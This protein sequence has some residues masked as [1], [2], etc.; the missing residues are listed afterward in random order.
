MTTICLEYEGSVKTPWYPLMFVVNTTS[1]TVGSRFPWS[2]PRKRVPSSR[3]RN[4]GVRFASVKV[5]RSGFLGP[6]RRRGRFLTRRL[7]RLLRIRRRRLERERISGVHLHGRLLSER[8]I[9]H[10]LGQRRATRG[11]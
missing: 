5:T 1:A 6:H 4:P 8:L 11:E 9:E 7:G 10:G 2:T 3:R